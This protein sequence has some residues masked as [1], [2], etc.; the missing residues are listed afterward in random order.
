MAIKWSWAWGPET[1]VQLETMGW[2]FQNNTP[3]YGTPRPDLVYTYPGSPTRYSWA[4][5][6]YYNRYTFWPPE[7]TWESEGWLSTAFYPNGSSINNLR[8]MEIRGAATGDSIWI[9]PTN[10]NEIWEMRIDNTSQGTFTVS[11]KDWHFI[12]MKY[13]MSTV[14]W[15]CEV[16]ID[17]VSVVSGTKTQ[18]NAESTGEFKFTGC[19]NGVR[20]AIYGQII[21]WDSLSDPGEV[22]RYVTRVNPTVDTSETGVWTPLA[23]ATTNYEVL[24]SPFDSGTYTTNTGSASGNKVICQ[25]TGASGLITQLG[26]IPSEIDGITVHCWASGSGQSG[27]AGL[28]DNDSVYKIGTAIVPDINDPT[29]C[30]ATSGSQPSNGDPWNATSSVYIKYEVS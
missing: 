28:S 4:Q 11:E 7:G 18:G 24:A 1:A 13:T 19:I 23:P 16:F 30:F 14:E 21:V 2:A 10:V 9:Q 22:P 27:V 17:G 6:E 8:C 26:T 25:V 3:T 29:Y 5:D 20:N 15:G 12:S